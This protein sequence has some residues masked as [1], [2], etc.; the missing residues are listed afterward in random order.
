MA[1]MSRHGNMLRGENPP[2]SQ[3]YDQGRFGRLFPTLQPFS[4]DT[5]T[6][7]AALLKIGEKGGI[8][9]AQ[10]DPMASPKDLIINPA[11]NVNNPNNPAMTA[12]MTF[13]GQFVD[14]DITLDTTSSLEQQ[15]D[16]EA[17]QN[18]RTPTLALDNIYGEGPANNAH[19]YDATDPVK[20]LVEVNTG[21]GA[22]ARDGVDR[23][24]LPR[25]SQGTALIGDVRSDENIVLSQL[26]LAFLLFHNACVDHVRATTGLTSPNAVFL[27]AQRLVRWHYQ[28]ILIHEFLPKTCG[29]AVVDDVMTNGRKF[30][31]WRN[32]PFI[33]VEFSVAAYRFGHSQVRPSYRMNFGPA[34]GGDVFLRLFV[35]TP[36]NSASADP[37]DMRGGLR[38]PRRFIDWQ[39]FFDFG[40]GNA[41]PN[42]KLDT[43]LSSV[44]M[45]LIGIPGAEPQS[46]AQRNLLRHLT[47]KVP[48][49]QSVAKA[50]DLPVL[51][52]GDFADLAA[53]GLDARTPLW[54][55]LLREAEKTQNGERLGAVGARI[56][57]EVFIG[58]IEGDATSYLAQ[59]SQW[60][61]SLPSAAG[62]GAFAM[63][64][65]L[66]FAGVVHPLA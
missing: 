5:P 31:N 22:A 3:Y 28:W 20:F 27:E 55:Y 40:D 56:V 12:G 9:D 46:L 60:V 49:G 35:D 65:L 36:A 44:L 21:S 54:F 57:T 17:I 41:R 1:K 62:P 32:E 52:K 42:K 34:A 59:D 6:I 33:P 19:L 64:D 16:P 14:H 30:Y 58:L 29:Q 8:I 63:T 15:V 61:P 10:D 4:A 43:K 48:S 26:H 66:K 53:F 38:Q 37:D 39:T 24:D 23:F 50:M 2:S 11:L 18:F 47:F 25:N 7:R 51:P 45:D 13:L